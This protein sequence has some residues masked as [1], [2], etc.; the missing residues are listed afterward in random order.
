MSDNCFNCNINNK[1]VIVLMLSEYRSFL[2]KH[3]FSLQIVEDLLSRFVIYAPSRIRHH[4][5]HDSNSDMEKNDGEIMGHGFTSETLYALINLW[6]LMNDAL[7]HG[8]GND[9][10]LTVGILRSKTGERRSNGRRNSERNGKISIKEEI[11]TLLRLI[12]TVV[13]CLAPA[14]EVRAYSYQL[15]TRQRQQRQQLQPR[16]RNNILLDVLTNIERIKF[17]CRLA[18]ILLNYSTSYNKHINPEKVV[19]KTSQNINNIQHRNE[20]DSNNNEKEKEDID[21]SC[22]SPFG[23]LKDGGIFD[24]GCNDAIS[25]ENERKRV[26]RLLYVGKRTGRKIITSRSEITENEHNEDSNINT[27]VNPNK[28]SILGQCKKFLELSILSSPKFKI[29]MLLFGEFLHLVRPFYFIHES[30]S[31]A[32]KFGSKDDAKQK[33]SYMMKA[34][35]RSLVIDILSYKSIEFS[36]STKLKKQIE[37]KRSNTVLKS[38]NERTYSSGSAN[39]SSYY[40]DTSSETTKYELYN[41]KMRL[42]LYSLRAPIFDNVTVHIA[43]KIQN[44]LNCIPL[45]G[46]PLA[47]YFLD[48]LAYWQ[49]WH[50]MLER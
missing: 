46:K 16:S 19:S 37:I 30:R 47:S 29:G 34:W 33:R 17:I 43:Q 3:R 21:M 50:F 6:S 25:S 15:Q 22:V 48:L 5:Y 45:L 39:T 44:I 49:H 1:N 26:R 24:F 13:D 42:M 12:L 18:I 10:G 14:F 2:Q 41:R 27:F 9:N 31:C 20:N 32:N 35:I 23:I 36:M 8:L 40:V 7:Y 38:E 11:I 4:A 28:S